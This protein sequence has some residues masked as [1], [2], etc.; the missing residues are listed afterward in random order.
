MSIRTSAL[1]LVLA[2]NTLPVVQSFVNYANDFINPDYILAG[3]FNDTTIPAQ[4]TIKQWAEDSTSGGPWSVTSKPYLA[5]SG[6]KHDYMSFS[7]YWWPNCTAVGNTTELTPQ[8]IWTTCPYYPRDGKF[9]PD[10]RIVNNIGDFDS[11][12]NAVLFNSLAW[13]ISS[14]DSKYSSRVVT[15]IK[16]WFLDEDTYMN[17]NLNYAQMQRGPGTEGQ[18]G[19]HTG[20]LD[21]KGMTK[22][23]S[24]V[25]ILRSGKAP[26]WTS[27]IDSQFNEWLKKYIEWL[28]TATIAIQEKN[29]T[30]NH[31]SFYFN[32]LAALQ[33]LVDDKA[34]AQ[35][36]LDEYFDGIYMGQIA[37]NGD[38]PL[39]SARTRPFHYRAYN[40]AAMITN[41][42]I[43][44]YLSPSTASSYWNRTTTSGA[45]IQQAALYAMDQQAGSEDPTELYPD[46][47]AVAAVYGD[48]DGKYVQWLKEKD[49]SG[50][51]SDASFLWDQPVGDA[52]FAALLV[53]NS[54]VSTSGSASGSASASKPGA[55][56]MSEAQTSGVS[57]EGSWRVRGM[58]YAACGVVMAVS[59][60]EFL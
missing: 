26:E 19:T 50:F 44:A 55:S 31:G 52:G 14:K 22:L 23:T 32:Q 34:G 7:P 6:D 43:A 5:P 10:A 24:G 4:S 20:I 59:F 33:V 54:S 40:L 16:A 8:Q 3:N 56:G 49:G 12:S 28:E 21:L 27:D 51:V 46:V 18:V 41:A 11:M 30:N 9:N 45:T 15:W 42:R 48:K 53:K 58:L 47:A 1:F 57:V 17:P 37:A 29:S 2:A 36:T 60:L 39:E 38:Q 13:A 25:L 35:K